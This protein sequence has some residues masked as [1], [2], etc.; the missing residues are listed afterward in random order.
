MPGPE[1]SDHRLEV[2]FDTLAGERSDEPCG[3]GRSDAR[4]DDGHGLGEILIGGRSDIDGQVRAAADGRSWWRCNG[5]RSGPVSEILTVVSAA[6]GFPKVTVPS[7]PSS[8][9]TVDHA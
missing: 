7:P 6:A 3:G 9:D 5:G 8:I 4:I 2:A 1:T